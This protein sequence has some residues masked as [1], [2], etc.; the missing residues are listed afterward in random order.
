MVQTKPYLFDK[1]KYLEK[2]RAVYHHFFFLL[3][4]INKLFFLL[5][6]EVIFLM[7]FNIFSVLITTEQFSLQFNFSDFTVV[8]GCDFSPVVGRDLCMGI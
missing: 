5:T 1:N 4:T 2:T 6:T 7:S 3:P 8:V